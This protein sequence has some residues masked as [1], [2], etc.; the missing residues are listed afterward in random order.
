MLEDL[1]ICNEITIAKLM[2]DELVRHCSSLR[3]SISAA[4]RSGSIP[5]TISSKASYGTST[6][7]FAT[8]IQFAVCDCLQQTAPRK[9]NVHFV[10]NSIKLCRQ[11]SDPSLI[12]SAFGNPP[13]TFRQI[14]LRLSGV[15][16]CSHRSLCK[17]SSGPDVRLVHTVTVAGPDIDDHSVA[18]MVE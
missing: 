4:S 18:G 9:M 10:S 16:E 8:N 2:V 6:Y 11:V 17:I 12:N 15:G 1:K 5:M 3:R 7:P 13:V 14:F